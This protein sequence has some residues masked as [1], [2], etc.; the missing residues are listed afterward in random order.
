MAEI[1][2]TGGVKTYTV[3]SS[4]LIFKGAGDNGSRLWLP[5]AFDDYGIK[6]VEQLEEALEAGRGEWC[7]D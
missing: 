3:S 5:V 4:E 6:T 1:N 2:Q 7:Q